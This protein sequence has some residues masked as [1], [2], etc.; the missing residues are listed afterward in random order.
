M[1]VDTRFRSDRTELMDD[2]Q[3]TGDLLGDTLDKLAIINRQL[4]GDRVTT[5]GVEA[6]LK[7][8]PLSREITFID[9]GCGDGSMLRLLADIGRK[10]GRSFKFIGLDANAYTVAHARSCSKAYPEVSFQQ[11]D[12]FSSQ[13]HGLSYDIALATLFMH[14][15][16]NEQIEEMLRTIASNARI[17]IVINDLKR[18]KVAYYLF[19]I[20]ASFLRNHMIKHDGEISI[21]RAFKRVDL[22][23]I[24]TKLGLKSEIRFKFAF[25]YQ[26]I[27]RTT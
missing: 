5:S 10:A 1:L 13:M 21:L 18:S 2:L 12:V 15:F 16:K 26:W 25:R 23:R 14:H 19:G 22:E 7:D 27:I 3:M 17:G 4:G 24:S 9:L 6:L 8:I 11:M 20:Y